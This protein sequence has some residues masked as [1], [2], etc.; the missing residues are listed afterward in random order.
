MLGENQI[1]QALYAGIARYCNKLAEVY[2]IYPLHVSSGFISS[3]NG[4][5]F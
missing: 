3:E 5:C 1:H 4:S 2:N